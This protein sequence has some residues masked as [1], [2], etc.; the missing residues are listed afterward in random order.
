M[1]FGH[2]MGGTALLMAERERPRTFAGLIVFEPIAFPHDPARP[3]GPSMMVVGARRRRA[4]FASRQ[5]AYDNYAGK[6]PLEALTPEALRAYVDHGFLDRPDGSV[7]LACEPEQ[8]ASIFDGGARQDA[9]AHLGEVPCPAITRTG[10]GTSPRW[11]NA[12]WRAPPSKMLASCSGS[13]ASSTEPSGRSR[14][15]WST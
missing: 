1:G 5:E 11:E 15:P 13:Q 12:S 6:P 3:D 2:S 14:K 9:F 8:E 4:V 7:E 10:Q